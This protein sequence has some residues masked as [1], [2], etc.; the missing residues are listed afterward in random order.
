M[1]SEKAVIPD[2]RIEDRDLQGI[3][4]GLKKPEK[5]ISPKFFYD[6]KGSQLFDSITEQPEYYPTQT[7]I[8]IMREN[9][10]DMAQRIGKQ[11]SLIEFGSGSSLKTPILLENLDEL[12]AYVPVDISKEHLLASSE[13]LSRDYPH[14]EILPVV[15]DFTHPFDLPTPKVMPKKNIVYF[16]GST[17]GNFPPEAALDL[18]RTMHTEAGEGGALLIGVD[19][20]KDIHTLEAAY[21][22][23]AGV[24]AEFNLNMLEHLNREFGTDFDVT[25]FSH[26]A[27]YN[28]VLGRIEMRLVSHAR[29]EV[30]VGGETITIEKGEAI[31]TETSQKYTL[32]GFAKLAEPAGFRVEKV[33]TDKDS[34]FSVQY[35]VRD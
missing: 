22:D 20:Q 24:T 5:E 11:A 33:W 6:E 23:A 26:L 12:A 30:H 13:A 1:N 32:E 35:L 28:P 18:L 31:L 2:N 14:I 34:L 3:I 19:L 15:A 16:P 9:V 4:E 21:N 17:I 8:A 29:Q 7:E 27:T 25:A 10:G